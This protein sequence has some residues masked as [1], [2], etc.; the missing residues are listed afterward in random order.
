MTRE[1]GS[2]ESLRR[3]ATATAFL[4]A[5]LCAAAPQSVSASHRPLAQTPLQV[6]APTM[7]LIGESFSLATSGGSGSGRVAFFLQDKHSTCRLIGAMLTSRMVA[8]CRI[9]AVKYGD[10]QFSLTRSDAVTVAFRKP[11]TRLNLHLPASV[12]IG[13]PAG[14]IVTGGSGTGALSLRLTDSNPLCSIEG[15]TVTAIG[16]TSCRVV[17]VKDGDDEFAQTQSKSAAIDTRPLYIGI[18]GPPWLSGLLGASAPYPG[19]RLVALPA[20]GWTGNVAPESFTYQWYRGEQEIPGATTN[21]YDVT[22]ADC[23]FALSV[24]VTAH[25]QRFAPW[26]A[27]SVPTL[28][29]QRFLTTAVPTIVGSQQAGRTVA[30]RPGVWTSGTTFAYQWYRNGALI[31][32]AT[33]SRY[34][35][36]EA[37]ESQA[38]Q[39]LITGNLSGYRSASRLSESPWMP[40]TSD[41]Y[42]LIAQRASIE[43][44]PADVPQLRITS[45]PGVDAAWLTREQRSIERSVALFSG[46]AH[47][48]NVDVVY[49]T[50]ADVVWAENLFAERGYQ[51]SNGVRWWMERDDCNIALSFMMGSTPVIFQCLGPNRDFA[52]YQQIGA[53]EYAHQIQYAYFP[54]TIYSMPGWLTEGS[55]SFFGIA[56]AVYSESFGVDAVDTYLRTYASSNYS[57]DAAAR[58][59]QGTSQLL[60]I[61][62]NGDVAAAKEILSW[63]S[64][65]GLLYVHT[66]FLLGG[67]MTEWLIDTY[68]LDQ[69]RLFYELSAAA[70]AQVSPNGTTFAERRLA[71]ENVARNVFGYNWEG[72][73]VAAMP[74]LAAR[75]NA[76]AALP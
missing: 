60:S 27:M 18:D 5:A 25:N 30:A 32:G 70:V 35:V 11:Q 53:H 73:L 6:Q 67:L 63:S 66:Q 33:A 14:A 68:G 9:Y 52:M 75:A 3:I 20:R 15:L 65:Y 36:T 45:A 57:L 7:N 46:F 2:R 51:I 13:V 29:V 12:Q 55:A 4:L 1:V 16:D 61:L 48:S 69:F 71:V 40:A 10:R 24:Q 56:S 72:L 39:V 62:R 28:P 31:P 17:A 19:L 76:M 47:P 26:V 58:L 38:L 42:G 49:A 22:S 74:Y 59:P 8:N 64:G 54:Q 50:G 43:P 23:G 41:L 34:R 44:N 21:L 37:D